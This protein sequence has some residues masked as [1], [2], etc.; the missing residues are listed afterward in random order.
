MASAVNSVNNPAVGVSG[1]G[2]IRRDQLEEDGANPPVWTDEAVAALLKQDYERARMYL[3]NNAWIACWEEND[4]LYQSPYLG[5]NANDPRYARVSRFGVNNQTNTM[6]DAVKRGL[7]AQK[8]C[9]L[10]RQRGSTTETSVKAWTALLDVLLDRMG[11]QYWV[12]LAIDS[13]ALHGTGVMKGGW[14]TR[15]IRRW[16]RKRKAAP[17]SHD[18]P[19]GPPQKVPTPASNSFE[20]VPEDVDES[21]PWIEFRMI[22]STMFDPGWRT[23]NAPN[24][25]SKYAIDIDFPTWQDLEE[26]RKLE[27]YD[28]PDEEWLKDYFFNTNGDGNP[29]ASNVEQTLSDQGSPVMHADDR[30]RTTSAD[31]TLAKI[32]L[33]ER[34]TEK[35]VMA[36]LLIN[37]RVVCIRNEDNK[38]NRLPHFTINWRNILNSGWGIGIGRL[39][40]GDQRLEQGTL[41]HAINLLAYQLSPAIL[42][43]AGMEG[44]AANR[45]VSAGGFFPVTPLNGDVRNSMAVMDMPKIPAE[46]WQMIQYAKSSSQETTGADATFMQGQLGG[47]GSS[48][49]RTA[50]GAGA[51]SVKANSRVQTPVENVELGIIVPYIEML[52]D[53]VKMWMP[54][55]EIQSILSTK[56][57]QEIVKELS[58]DDFDKF[59][60]AEIMVE[61]LAGAKLAAKVAMAQQLPWLMQIFQQPQIL[62]QL[63][64]EGKTVDLEVILDILFQVSEFRQEEEIIREMTPEEQAAVTQANQVNA[65]MQT[66]LAIEQQKGQNALQKSDRDAENKVATTTA[67]KAMDH[68]AA[69]QPLD[70]AEGLVDRADDVARLRGQ[71]PSPVAGVE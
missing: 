67:E 60:T 30:A 13:Q 24:K 34:T 12:G 70:R 16:T 5:E 15:T 21:Y 28:I 18:L 14:S 17:E 62:E 69:R 27:C 31:P 56:L 54:I 10:L 49:A 59:L 61:V 38:L 22:G 53:M 33:I 65:K 39:A 32:A 20:L 57:E 19:L 9:F 63:H 44:F 41:N 3:E 36:G 6:A 2:E 40:G 23:P 29:T 7:F 45:Q 48:A 52:I 47:P 43:A 66:A 71:G 1:Y 26:M 8:P 25:S 64:A 4:I 68:L 58:D 46:A 55:E 11:F 51:I 35:N 42:Y 37:G 50:T